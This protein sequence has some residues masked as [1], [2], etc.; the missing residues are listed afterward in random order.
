MKKNRAKILCSFKPAGNLTWISVGS[1]KDQDHVRGLISSV[2][3]EFSPVNE[4]ETIPNNQTS[5]IK[6]IFDKTN[7]TIT[8]IIAFNGIN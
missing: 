2:I 7:G 8:K 3:L 5:N 6:W 1:K 4:F